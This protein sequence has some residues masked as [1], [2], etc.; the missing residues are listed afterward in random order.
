[1]HLIQ[2]MS[3]FLYKAITSSNKLQ[4]P[5]FKMFRAGR[6]LAYQIIKKKVDL[7]NLKFVT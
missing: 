6:D 1:M 7:L 3:I 4:F 5:K 2:N